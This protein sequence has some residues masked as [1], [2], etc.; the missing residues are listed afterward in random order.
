MK[1]VVA[2]KP[3]VARDIAKVLKCGERGEGCLKGADY[4]VS[5]AAAPGA[6]RFVSF[7]ALRLLLRAASGIDPV[8]DQVGQEADDHHEHRAVQRHGLHQR[9]IAV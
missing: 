8:R 9:E 7:H 2:E 5:W 4:M 6:T 1:L 3:S